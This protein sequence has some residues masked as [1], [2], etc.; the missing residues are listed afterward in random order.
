MRALKVI[1]VAAMLGVPA[2]SAAAQDRPDPYSHN[3]IEAGQFA[4]AETSLRT[5]LALEPTK[6]ELLINLAAIY[7][8]TNRLDAAQTMYDRALAAENVSLLLRPDFAQDSHVIAKRG[9]MKLERQRMA[10]R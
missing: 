10:M 1:I 2:V 8:R 4:E 9:M 6:P 5:Q 7:A 3:A